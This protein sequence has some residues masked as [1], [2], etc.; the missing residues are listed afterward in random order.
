MLDRTKSNRKKE[1]QEQHV[2]NATISPH[3][4]HERFMNISGER[5]WLKVVGGWHWTIGC[6]ALLAC[7]LGA[8]LAG[9]PAPGVAR[10]WLESE[11][12]AY[13]QTALRAHLRGD[14]APEQ[15]LAQTGFSRIDPALPRPV[16]DAVDFYRTR[17]ETP[18]WGAVRLLRPLVDGSPIYLVY[19]TTDGDDGWVELY[20]ANGRLLGAARRYLEL[21]GWGDRTRLRAQTS[22]GA[23]PPDLADRAERTIWAHSH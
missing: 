15:F 8:C 12:H 21:L 19:V 18:D 6:T 16:Q 7:L 2:P 4:F 11:L 10:R 22:T 5:N 23:F 13:W 17:V 1:R 3:P 9:P 20:D 14:E